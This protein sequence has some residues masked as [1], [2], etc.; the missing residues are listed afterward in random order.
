MLLELTDIDS[1]AFYVI[2]KT[3]LME[4]GVGAA[5]FIPA[6]FPSYIILSCSRSS[7]K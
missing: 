7:L 4:D 1:W 6:I 2:L 5:L 3:L